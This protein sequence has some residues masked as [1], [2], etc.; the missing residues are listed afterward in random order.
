MSYRQLYD[1]AA[2]DADKSFVV[3]AGFRYKILYAHA[4][5]VTTATVSNR[6]LGMEVLDASANHAYHA[7]AGSDQTPSSDREYVYFP[8]G[9][10]ETSFR[11]NHII[12]PIPKELILLSG[13][14]LRF[15]DENEV[16]LAA[17]DLT[18][19]VMVDSRLLNEANQ[20]PG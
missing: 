12:V 17:D 1:D 13:W 20:Y 7:I 11:D 16:D 9:A 2:N 8:N 3:P 18:V 4:E 19:S 5:F 14:T 10:P 15:H 6:L